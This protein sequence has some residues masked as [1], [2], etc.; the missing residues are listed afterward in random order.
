MVTAGLS[1]DVR[2]GLPPEVQTYI[3][4]LEA[5]L[6]AAD[7]QISLNVECQCNRCAG[8]LVR[9]GAFLVGDEEG[10]LV[11]PPALAAQVAEAAAKNE[12]LDRFLMLTIKGDEP[13]AEAFPPRERVRG[14]FEVW[15]NRVKAGLKYGRIPDSGTA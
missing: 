3:A 9:P 14:E 1:E 11:I 10:V 4:T 7:G 5:R 15:R 2:T 13:L 6:Q 12:L 8:V